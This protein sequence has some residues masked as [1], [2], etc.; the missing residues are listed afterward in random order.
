MDEQRKFA[1]LFAATIPNARPESHGP[2]EIHLSLAGSRCVRLRTVSTFPRAP[3]A[4]FPS[5]REPHRPEELAA[6]VADLDDVATEFFK[7]GVTLF[8]GQAHTSSQK[9][10]KWAAT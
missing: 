10:E 2:L 1:I 8:R 9:K 6:F 4:G 3:N 5:A 7:Q